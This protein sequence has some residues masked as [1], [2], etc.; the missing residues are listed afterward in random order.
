MING[1]VQDT[2]YEGGDQL[3][4]RLVNSRTF[5]MMVDLLN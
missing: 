4:L 3:K 5:R 2:I 1:D